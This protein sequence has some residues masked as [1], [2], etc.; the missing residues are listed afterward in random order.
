MESKT[1]YTSGDCVE[2]DG[3]CSLIGKVVVLAPD[4]KE[5]QLNICICGNGAGENANGKVLFLISLHTGAFVLKTKGDMIGILKPE[6]LPESAKL[7]LAK[8]RPMGALS[9]DSNTPQYSTQVF[10]PAGRHD[11]GVRLCTLAEV[12]NYIGMQMSYQHRVTVCDSSGRCIIELLDGKISHPADGEGAI[13]N[14]NK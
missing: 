4:S 8:I 9:L 6:M 2:T 14:R 1:E 13:S 11:S 7:Q 10:T 5:G 3:N 12:W